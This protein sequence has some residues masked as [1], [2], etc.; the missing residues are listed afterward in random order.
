MKRLVSCAEVSSFRSGTS[1]TMYVTVTYLPSL[2]VEFGNVT[3]TTRYP[4]TGIASLTCSEA[5]NQPLESRLSNKH[6]E[7][8]SGA[9]LSFRAR[10]PR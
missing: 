7:I 8:L 4:L 1:S 2:C 5:N 10:E 3:L 6:D 9:Q